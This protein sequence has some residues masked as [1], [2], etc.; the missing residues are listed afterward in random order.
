M[1]LIQQPVVQLGRAAGKQLL[2]RLQ[3]PDLPVQKIL[4]QAEFQ[5]LEKKDEI[6][7]LF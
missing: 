7:D 6:A 1:N 3:H 5:P 4:L 2:E